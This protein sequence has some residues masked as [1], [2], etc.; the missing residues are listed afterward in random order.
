V[1][2]PEAGYTHDT[3]RFET[4]TKLSIIKCH[5]SSASSARCHL[6]LPTVGSA[7][8]SSKLVIPSC[9]RTCKGSEPQQEG[10]C[11]IL[12][13]MVVMVNDVYL[14]FVYKSV[15]YLLC[16]LFLVA[17]S[18]HYVGSLKV[19]NPPALPAQ[20]SSSAAPD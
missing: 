10:Q 19:S 16:I 11:R 5:T 4:T 13:I 18:Y 20:P 1:P 17:I 12:E 2:V 9:P 14:L 3:T 6:T 7:I 15:V 8:S